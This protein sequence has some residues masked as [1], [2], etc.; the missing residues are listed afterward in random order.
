MQPRLRAEG[1]AGKLPNLQGLVRPALTDGVIWVEIDLAQAIVRSVP[2]DQLR[3]HIARSK[4]W[5]DTVCRG[6]RPRSI[7]TDQILLCLRPA[8]LKDPRVERDLFFLWR[9]SHADLVADVE[10]ADFDEAGR[11]L[12]EKWPA[13]LLRIALVISGRKDSEKILSQLR[14]AVPDGTGLVRAWSCAVEGEAVRFDGAKLK[15]LEAKVRTLR[16]KVRSLAARY[17]SLQK[18]LAMT[19]QEVN[20]LTA[21]VRQEVRARGAAEHQVQELTKTL[22]TV[23]QRLRMYEAS[24]I[25]EIAA[26]GV[27]AIPYKELGS[28]SR[29]RLSVLA[30]VRL[31]LTASEGDLIPV[32]RRL[33]ELVQMGHMAPFWVAHSSE[34][35]LEIRQKPNNHVLLGTA[36]LMEDI[37]ELHHLIT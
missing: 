14:K 17:K 18:Q 21:R 29:T 25:Q 34:N 20:R 2:I 7:S 3:T 19:Q 31:V 10:V 12:V 9:E 4:F 28:D 8:F 32:S 33:V 36:V 22:H 1:L 11:A 30:D 35:Q 24:T 6:F 16:N 26:L 15:Q 37:Y 23:E 5:R 27:V 13:E